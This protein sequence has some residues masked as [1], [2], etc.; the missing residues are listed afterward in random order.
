MFDLG[1][2]EKL[3][4]KEIIDDIEILHSSNCMEAFKCAYTLFKKKWGMNK[5][6]NKSIN[7]GF[8]N[9][10]DNESSNQMMAGMKI[11]NC[12][13]QT[14]TMPWK[15]SIK[16]SKMMELLENVTFYQGF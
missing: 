10:F 6:K 9:Y 16:Q 13:H 15:Q 1:I 12:V 7:I 2:D 14:Q 8:S 4:E 5:K 3:I 11:Y